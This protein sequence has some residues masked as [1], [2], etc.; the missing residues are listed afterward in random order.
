VHKLTAA[1][2]VGPVVNPLTARAQ[3][4]GGMA[5]GV[6]TALGATISLKGGRVQEQHFNDFKWLRIPDMPEMEI[7]FIQGS[8]TP[9][10]L[11][12]VG[13]PATAPAI[14][15]A[16]YAL[17]GRRIRHLPMLPAELAGWGGAVEPSPTPGATTVPTTVPT[18]VPT[19]APT[20]APDRHELFVPWVR[21]GR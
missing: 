16:V 19:Q 12:E 1:I 21:G 20:E 5:D 11:G 17:T 10:G 13:Y 6:A 9:G 18:G 2:D 15:N 7:H 14:A 4:E 3:V 8:D